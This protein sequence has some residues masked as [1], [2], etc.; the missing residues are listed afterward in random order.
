MADR[1]SRFALV[2]LGAVNAL[3][4]LIVARPQLLTS[5]AR[6]PPL[7]GLYV[8]VYRALSLYLF[9]QAIAALKPRIATVL[10]TVETPEGASR[11]IPGL[12][13]VKNILETGFEEYYQRWKQAQFV[14]VNREVA[15]HIRQVSAIVTAKYSTLSRL[16]TGLMAL[17][18]LTAALITMLVFSRVAS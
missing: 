8:A 11:P 9:V 13:F 2:I 6:Q 10:S 12:R 3:N 1:R 15:L 18:F 4:L 5:A 14:D 7:L 17:V 16:Y